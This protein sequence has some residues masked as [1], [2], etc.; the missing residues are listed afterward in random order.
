VTRR[1]NYSK[2]VE[3]DSFIAKFMRF[4]Q[5]LETSYSYDFWAACWLIAVASG[6]RVVIPRPRAPVYLNWYVLLL[7]DS[8][9]TRK[10]T[11]IRNAVRVAKAL[12]AQL[13]PDLTE[14]IE[15]GI[16]PEAL[17]HNLAKRSAELGTAN[18][19][20]ASSE[21]VSLLGRERYKSGLPGVLTDLYDCPSSHGA[22]LTGFKRMAT[23]PFVTLL[24][25]STP[26][27]LSTSINADI[28]AGGFTS[29]CMFVI[30][31]KRKQRVAWPSIRDNEAGEIAELSEHLLRI[32]ESAEKIAEIR[33]NDNAMK[34]YQSW[35]NRKEHHTDAF[36][37][38]FESREDDHVLRLAATLAISDGGWLIDTYHFTKAAAIINEIKDDGMKL[39]SDSVL[40]DDAV[41]AIDKLRRILILAGIDG[42]RQ[43]V[44]YNKMRTKLNA[45]EFN[46]ALSIMHELGLVTCQEAILGPGKPVRIWK[47]TRLMTSNGAVDAILK[48]LTK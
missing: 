48:K 36:R 33:L 10:S 14:L 15:G 34:K 43:G 7:A 17:V 8:G 40:V 25:A 45:T 46:A 4:M 29:R 6:R 3:G 35:Y 5:P 20:L 2:H 21:L 11:A 31:E 39:F 26:T 38:S 42:I 23:N 44:L 37:S 28:I 13:H 30:S 27:W 12:I 1:Y 9:V 18:V 32:H 47:A 19:A 16:T 22:V 24:G 41:I